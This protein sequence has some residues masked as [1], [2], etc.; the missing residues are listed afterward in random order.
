[1]TPIAIAGLLVAN[2]VWAIGRAIENL[3]PA[4]PKPQFGF[5]FDVA[6][7]LTDDQIEAI[8]ARFRHEIETG[9]PRFL[10]GQ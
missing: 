2:L 6:P 1:M 9:G 10:E 3:L 8:T 7:P 4:K 5:T